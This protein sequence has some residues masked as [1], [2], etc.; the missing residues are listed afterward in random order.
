MFNLYKIHMMSKLIHS[1]SYNS[2]IMLFI[3]LCL[4]F[5]MK[6]VLKFNS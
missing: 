6:I 3:T 1:S 2:V 4:C 5:N